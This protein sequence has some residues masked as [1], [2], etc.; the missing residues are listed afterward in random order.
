MYLHR[1]GAPYLYVTEHDRTANVLK[2]SRDGC[3][4]STNVLLMDEIYNS[5][6]VE[7]RSMAI[8]IEIRCTYESQYIISIKIN[9]YR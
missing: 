3:L 5:N 7:F 2:Y 9:H 1:L 6:S 8:G 4:L